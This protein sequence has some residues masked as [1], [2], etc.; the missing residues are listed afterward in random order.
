MTKETIYIER[1]KKLL[2]EKC[3][4]Y[5]LIKEKLEIFGE[6][7][8]L[9]NIFC[10]SEKCSACKKK[11]CRQFPCLFSPDDFLDI[12]D[13][14][15]MKSILDLGIL[16]ISEEQIGWI[17]YLVIRPKNFMDNGMMV[18]FVNNSNT[19]HL[20]TCILFEPGKGC[21]LDS[22]YRP[23]EGLCYVPY[24]NLTPYSCRSFYHEQQRK[25]EWLK[26]QDVLMKLI[27]EYKNVR[28]EENDD[29]ILKEKVRLLEKRLAGYKR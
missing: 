21:M 1:R 2:F 28:I 9:E 5:D 8:S 27:D 15:Y 7:V 20:N 29:D 26:C 23:S 10:D 6:N 11:C 14:D 25:Q 18:S 4:K 16:C 12:H 24:G 17:S 22:N 3:K 19:K 13:L